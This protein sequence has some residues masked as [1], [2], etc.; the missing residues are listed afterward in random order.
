[1]KLA[2][3][4]RR[5]RKRTP[6]QTPKNVTLTKPQRKKENIKNLTMKKTRNNATNPHPLFKKNYNLTSP[7][8]KDKKKKEN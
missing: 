5:K 1:M 6:Q 3:K 4:T 7:R 2:N 8:K